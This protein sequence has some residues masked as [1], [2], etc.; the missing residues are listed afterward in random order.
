MPSHTY[1]F[2]KKYNKNNSLAGFSSARLSGVYIRVLPMQG[3]NEIF[4]DGVLA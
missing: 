4:L 2:Y 3:C 1:L